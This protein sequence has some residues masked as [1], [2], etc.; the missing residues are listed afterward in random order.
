MSQEEYWVEPDLASALREELE[1]CAAALERLRERLAPLEALRQAAD[2]RPLPPPAALDAYAVDSSLVSPP[3]ELVGGVF[4]LIT[5]GYVGLVGGQVDRFL[6]AKLYLQDGREAD[7]TRYASLLERRL[8]ARLL[9]SRR[10]HLL[11]LDG[12]IAVHPL[13]YNLAREKLLEVNA[14][15]GRLLAAAR[16]SGISVA[17]V[18]KRVRSRL[19]SVLAGRCTPANDRVVASRLLRPGEYL[20]L[21]K[22]R[23]L[24]PRW[25][26]IHYADCE[27]GEERDSILACAAGRSHPPLGARGQRLCTRIREFEKNFQEVL[28]HGELGL[29]GEVHVAYYVPP[30]QRL[31]V[32]VELL[33]MGLG[34]ER[35]LGYLA[36]TASSLT[37]FPALLDAVDSY[38][39]APQELLDTALVALLSRLPP[40]AATALLPANPQKLRPRL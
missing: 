39:R 2:I 30:G 27:G 35:A 14:T 25:A 18:A 15:V 32:R 4:T 20:Y 5:Y 26:A 40:E 13:P 31:A 21:G 7:L 3:M 23:D 29:L 37:G 1:R 36:H 33:D 6:T 12:D 10:F 22:Y 8:A 9:A 38:V 28:D 19:L 34:L 11:M 17:G 24:L 16:R